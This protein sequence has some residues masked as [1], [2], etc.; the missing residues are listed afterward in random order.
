MGIILLAIIYVIFSDGESEDKIE[1]GEWRF[2]EFCEKCQ[3]PGIRICGNCGENLTERKVRPII[4]H[5]RYGIKV[6]DWEK[7]CCT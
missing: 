2:Q 7:K 3:V 4:Q 5:T 1:K 6:L